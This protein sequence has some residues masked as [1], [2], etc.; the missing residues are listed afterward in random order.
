MDHHNIII[1]LL[2]LDYH[3]NDNMKVYNED[4]N[5]LVYQNYQKL[6]QFYPK[7]FQKNY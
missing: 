7:N 1:I 5:E 6:N 2:I 4:E 3:N